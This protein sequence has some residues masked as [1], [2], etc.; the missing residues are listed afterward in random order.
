MRWREGDRSGASEAFAQALQRVPRHGFASTMVG[1]SP[2][3]KDPGPRSSEVDVAMV[4]AV[5]RTCAGQ[6][7]E[8]AAVVDAALATAPAGNHGW[9]LPVEPLLQVSGPEWE[10]VLARLGSRAA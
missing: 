5:A 8:A 9:I 10:P 7:A 6:R 4:R 2:E 3:S 1:L